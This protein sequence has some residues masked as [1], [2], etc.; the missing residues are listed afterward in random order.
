MWGLMGRCPLF[1]NA[2]PASLRMVSAVQMPTIDVASV[3]NGC[4]EFVVQVPPGR[5]LEDRVLDAL[6]LA[7]V[8]ANFAHV[9][10]ER[11]GFDCCSPCGAPDEVLI[12]DKLR[13]NGIS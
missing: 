9:D 8:A 10:P 5:R 3:E 4:T 6:R 11:V 1:R 13:L 7:E 2:Q 12:A